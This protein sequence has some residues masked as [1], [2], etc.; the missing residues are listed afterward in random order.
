M[1]TLSVEKR[2]KDA[3]TP[4][5][6]RRAGSIPAVVY[7]AH[8]ASTPIAVD[9]RAFGKVLKE[10]GEATIVSLFGLGAPLPTLIHEVDLDPL[11]N[12]PR[13]VDFYAVTKGEKVEVAIP[14]V[15]RGES[16]AVEAGA[17]LVKVLHEIEVEAD[18]MN[19]PHDITIDLSIL[20]NT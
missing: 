2:G 15:F 20:A 13:H 5:A 10:A 12:Q 4:V 6:L 16:P 9:A 19:L 11:T 1:L 17:N 18:P 7:G 14:L 3:A 8:H